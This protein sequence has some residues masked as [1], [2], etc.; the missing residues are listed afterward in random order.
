MYIP[1]CIISLIHIFQVCR[2]ID[3]AWWQNQRE[4]KLTEA[5][6]HIHVSVNGSNVSRVF[7]VHMIVIDTINHC[8]HRSIS[9]T[10]VV[11]M[12]T[13]SNE[14]ISALLARSPVNSPHKGPWRGAL[15]FSLICAWINSWVNN[16][17]AGGLRRH[18]CHY[19]V[20]VMCL[21]LH[22]IQLRIHGIA[23]AQRS[24]CDLLCWQAFLSN[25]G[26][27]LISY[28]SYNGFLFFKIV[29]GLFAHYDKNKGEI[30]SLR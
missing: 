11:C 27:Q 3:C 29:E 10:N 19:D 14:N 17:D 20:I 2:G 21:L 8:A 9:S 15:M 23:C 1:V 7:Q 5:D 4:N 25:P 24:D 28:V 12:M 16:R 22:Q 26:S 30:N 18:R 6:W 13:S